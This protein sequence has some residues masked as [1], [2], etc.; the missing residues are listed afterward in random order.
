MN[1]LHTIKPLQAQRGISLLNLTFFLAIA[2][3]CGI[4]AFKVIPI[5]AENRYVIT[6]LKELASGG[7]KLEQMS[8]AEIKKSMSNFYLL[9]NVRTEGP[10][11][12]AIKRQTDQ[13]LITVDYEARVPF[14]YNI[15][16][17]VSFKNHLNSLRP[18]E[19]CDASDGK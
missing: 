1:S 13:V 5:Y 7:T 10:K 2:A 6:G 17:V 4:F 3:F 9:N 18:S 15:D 11:N 16:L 19:C 14:I 12:V 8:D